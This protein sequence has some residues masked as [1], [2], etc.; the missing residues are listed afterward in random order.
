M[1]VCW[2]PSVRLRISCRI[3]SV[4]RNQRCLSPFCSIQ[5]PSAYVVPDFATTAF[6]TL[7]TSCFLWFLHTFWSRNI[8]NAG[9]PEPEGLAVFMIESSAIVLPKIIC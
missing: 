3:S 7:G 9:K 1:F 6:T 2:N 5:H 8:S 4:V